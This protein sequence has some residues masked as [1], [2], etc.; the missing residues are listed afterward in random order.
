M[1]S[2]CHLLLKIL[3]EGPENTYPAFVSVSNYVFWLL[4]TYSREGR[5]EDVYNKVDAVSL[6]QVDKLARQ[7]HT[8]VISC[9]LDL[10]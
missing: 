7:D 1:L 5:G 9:E 3:P 4:Q 2:P 8:A 10:K 6:E